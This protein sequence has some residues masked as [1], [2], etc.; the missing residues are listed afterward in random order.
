MIEEQ[1][2]PLLK[3]SVSSVYNKFLANLFLD[4]E[5]KEEEEEVK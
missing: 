3:F 4:K 1:H 5:E 2:L